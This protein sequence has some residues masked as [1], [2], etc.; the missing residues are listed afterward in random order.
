MYFGNP[1]IIS[2]PQ[3]YPGNRIDI[4]RNFRI[5]LNPPNMIRIVYVS[6]VKQEGGLN[7]MVKML[8]TEDDGMVE[9]ASKV[10]ANCN[11][12]FQ[13]KPTTKV[14]DYLSGRV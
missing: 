12:A 4:F 1:Q 6:G 10:I 14:T 5:V 8:N 7:L 9:A 3:K 11:G 2:K 13:A